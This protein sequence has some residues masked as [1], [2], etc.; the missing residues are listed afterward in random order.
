VDEL[1]GPGAKLMSGEFSTSTHHRVRHACN[2]VDTLKM[3]YSMQLQA[4][5]DAEVDMY[6]W[7]YK[8]PFGGAFRS[9]WSFSEL[10]YLLGVSNRPDVDTF[11]CG[12]HIPR[13]GEFTDD[14]FSG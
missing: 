8:M 13:D 1:C 14:F 4:A 6:Y 10:M 2:D 7:S 9:A 5:K 3:S 11:N 12:G